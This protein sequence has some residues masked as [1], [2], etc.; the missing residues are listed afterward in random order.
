VVSWPTAIV[1]V[2]LYFFVFKDARLYADM[3]LQV[4]YASISA[5]GW[6]HWLHGGANRGTLRVSRAPRAVWLALPF[7]WI[8]G[9]FGLGT[10][11][12]RTTDAALPYV[13]SALTVGS[14]LAQWMMTRNTWRTGRS[15]WD[16][17]WRT[18]S[19]SSA[20]TFGLRPSCTSSMG[21]SPRGDSWNGGAP[22]K[23]H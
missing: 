6:Y 4:F 22:C 2:S 15:G 17:T 21:S 19:S 10:L 9:T 7:A 16:S 18:S 12:Q 5:Y 13:D 20:A 23:R 14:L 8:L 1:S 11:L 3:G